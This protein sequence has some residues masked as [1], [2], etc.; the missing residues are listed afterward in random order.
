MST[1]KKGAGQVGVFRW[2]SSW[3]AALYVFLYLPMLVLLVYS[4]NEGKRVLIW[5][6]FAPTKWYVKALNNEAIQD[7]AI[8]SLILAVIAT[9]LATSIALAVA[10]VLAR[11]GSFR[12]RSVTQGLIM[13]PLVVPE[14]VTA[15]ATA[16]F[17]NFVLAKIGIELG[18]GSLIIAHTVFCIPFA[19]MPIR[20]RLQDMNTDLEQAA[21][22]LYAS[23]WEAFRLIT[24]PLMMPGIIAGAVLAFVISLDDFIISNFVATAGSTTLPVYIYSMIRQGVSPEVNA[25]STILFAISAV[26]VTIYWFA[27]KP[28]N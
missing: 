19:F 7:A 26:L 18:F 8:T 28:K 1:K 25:V 23:G 20:A 13:L 9:V 2:L 21:C 10:L 3:T 11:A 16:V 27:S 15:V 14:I 5:T 6:G 12:G 17:L 24:L 22:D 4:F